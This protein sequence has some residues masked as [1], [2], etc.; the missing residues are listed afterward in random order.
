M[1]KAREMGRGKSPMKRRGGREKVAEPRLLGTVIQLLLP[2]I[3]MKSYS[4]RG[5]PFERE[6]HDYLLR[7]FSGYTVASGNI[8]GYW[9][10]E[11]RNEDCNEHREYQIALN[12]E[13]ERLSLEKRVS[14]LAKEL[15][16]QT[17]FCQV[18]GRAYLIQAEAG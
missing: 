9:R 10:R 14:N 4:P 17:I 15:G 16:E 13:K 3:K 12:G 11:G 2:S 7:H 1:G 5:I 18:N 6:F 8:T